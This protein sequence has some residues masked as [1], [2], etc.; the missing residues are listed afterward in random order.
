MH[1]TPYRLI[2]LRNR[3]GNV[4]AY[5]TVDAPDYPRLRRTNWFRSARGYAVCNVRGYRA[6][7]HR[8]V[9]GLVGGDGQ[10]VDHANGDKLDNRRSN[11]RLCPRGQRDNL[12]NR[13]TLDPRNSSGY[14]GV[15]WDRKLGKWWAR[16]KIGGEHHHIGYFDDPAEAGDAA[17][18]YRREH[19]PFATN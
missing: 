9:L 17:A 4:V 7:M 5:A 19:M 2:P 13:R 11:L 6:Y 1:D 18:R 12:Q 3:K 14:R 15:T 16:A 8:E 10:S